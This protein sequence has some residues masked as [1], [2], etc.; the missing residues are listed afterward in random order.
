MILIQLKIQK[1]Q[2]RIL[3]LIDR[4]KLPDGHLFYAELQL[5]LF[6]SLFFIMHIFQV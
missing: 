2:K 6:I 5:Y 1:S 4:A 3:V